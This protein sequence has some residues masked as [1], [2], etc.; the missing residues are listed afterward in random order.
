MKK[1]DA[2][3]F[4]NRIDVLGERIDELLD[5]E[6]VMVCMA[7][8]ARLMGTGLAADVI[9]RVPKFDDIDVSIKLLEGAIRAAYSDVKRAMDKGYTQ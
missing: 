2:D 3:E 5:G 4:M 8:L 1:I 7:T 6:D 9:G